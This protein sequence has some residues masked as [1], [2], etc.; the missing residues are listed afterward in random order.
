MRI[1]GRLGAARMTTFIS[2]L[3]TS[4]DATSRQRSSAADGCRGVVLVTGMRTQGVG[5]RRNEN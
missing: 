4:Y 5:Q 2:K 1:S 3:I